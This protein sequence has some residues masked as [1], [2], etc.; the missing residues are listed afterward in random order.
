MPI[1]TW[2]EMRTSIAE[3]LLRQTGHDLDW[4]NA[5]IVAE[6]DVVDEAALRGWLT[7][8]GVTGYQQMLLVMERFG[9]PDY[10]LASA[11]ELLDGQYRDRPRLRPILDAVVAVAGTFGPIDVQARKT[12]TTLLTPRRTFAA[13]KPATRTRVDLALRLDGVEPGG[14]LLDGSTT[15]GGGINLRIAL[16]S[17]DDLDDEAVALLRRAYDA[18]L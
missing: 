14:R 1:R 17:V 2:E 6:G 4:W 5:R 9:Y 10:L 16:A 3:R 7:E 11:E 8:S 18:G 15:A 13:V 12:Y